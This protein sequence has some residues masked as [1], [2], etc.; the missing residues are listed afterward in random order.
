MMYPQLAKVRY[1]EM[2]EAFRNKKVLVLS[3]VENWVI[4]P[5]L[6]FELA[7]CVFWPR[8]IHSPGDCGRRG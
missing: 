1:E 7:N 2:G 3:L 5:L 4:G 6:R 8:K